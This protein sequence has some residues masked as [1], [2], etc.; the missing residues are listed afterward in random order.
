MNRFYLKDHFIQYSLIVIGVIAVFSLFGGFM[1]D[2]HGFLENVLVSI[3]FSGITIIVG[4]FFVDRLIEHRQEQQW[5][6]VRLLTY[7]GLAAHLCDMASMTMIAFPYGDHRPAGRIL[8]GRNEPREVSGAGFERL[9]DG[10]RSLTNSG[11]KT[12]SLSDMAVE[13]YEMVRWDL[14]QIQTVLTPRLLESA[15]DQ[16]LIDALM[17][18]DHA[19]R[20]LYSAILGHK[21]I[22]TQSAYHYIPDVIAAAGHL[23]RE[24][25]LHWERAEQDLAKSADNITERQAQKTTYLLTHALKGG[26]QLSLIW[27][28]LLS[29]AKR[30]RKKQK[31]TTPADS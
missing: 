1:L 29:L 22:V 8:E 20:A 15:T 3:A 12:K 27:H 14:E 19:H 7:R 17:E 31:A 4:L 18:F 21:L 11:S 30:G 6:R 26:K 5:A 23:Y 24:M 28:R 25:R 9:T 10:L 2:W 16:K 13:F